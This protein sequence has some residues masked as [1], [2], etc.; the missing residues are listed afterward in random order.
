MASPDTRANSSDRG[1]SGDELDESQFNL[2]KARRRSNSSLET[3]KSFKSKFETIEKEPVFE[4]SVHGDG[5][6]DHYSKTSLA[7]G[8]VTA[9]L[10][11]QDS[12]DSTSSNSSAASIDMDVVGPKV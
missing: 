7:E 1:R 6:I 12:I 9:E 5:G 10:D 11:K 2:T 4:E 8:G 3:G